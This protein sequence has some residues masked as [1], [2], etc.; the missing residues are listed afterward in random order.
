[1]LECGKEVHRGPHKNCAFYKFVERT[2]S[3]NEK[4]VRQIGDESLYDACRRV[5]KYENP[6]MCGDS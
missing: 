4:L 6:L 5:F 3:Q 2:K 1:V